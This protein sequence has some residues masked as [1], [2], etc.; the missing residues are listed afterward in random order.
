M[1]KLKLL[2]ELKV[3]TIQN[4]KQVEYFKTLTIDK[5][6]F[7]MN[8]AQWSI[9]E[10]I[11]HLNRYGR[12]YIPEISK[13]IKNNK[14]PNSNI[15]KSGILGNYFSKSMK[16]KEKLNKMKTFPSMNPKGSNLSI[17]VLEEFIIQQN[18]L[19]ELLNQANFVDLTKIKT[20]ISISKC[21]KLRLGDTLRVVIYH[22]KRHISQANKCVK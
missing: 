3:D 9:L 11:E 12:F 17:E 2:E 18:S 22:N 1:D 19:L 7:K 20:N 5:L 8:D 21:I 13:R 14:Y 4:I 15:F 16:P 10:C 6:N